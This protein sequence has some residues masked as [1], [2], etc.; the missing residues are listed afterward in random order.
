MEGWEFEF[1]DYET[2]IPN[3]LCYICGVGVS[4]VSLRWC[5]VE[6]YHRVLAP[7]GLGLVAVASKR[8]VAS[9]HWGCARCERCCGTCTGVPHGN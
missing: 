4:L 5:F 6:I 7:S 9:R 1:K 2:D 3:E 8:T